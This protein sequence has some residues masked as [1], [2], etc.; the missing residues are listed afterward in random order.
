M[1]NYGLR[2]AV[3]LVIATMV[4]S[5]GA[6]S[7]EIAPDMA[8]PDG[9]AKAYILFLQRA[10]Y[11]RAYG[12]LTKSD[13]LQLSLDGYKETL[14][15]EAWKIKGT[16]VDSNLSQE[17]ESKVSAHLV[18]KTTDGPNQSIILNLV[19]APDGKWQVSHGDLAKAA[20]SAK[21]RIIADV[22]K[23]FGEGWKKHDYTSMSLALATDYLTRNFGASPYEAKLNDMRAKW[24]S[25]Y[26]PLEGIDCTADYVRY[27]KDT[28]ATIPAKF[29]YYDAANKTYRFAPYMVTLRFDLTSKQWKILELVRTSRYQRPPEAAAITSAETWKIEDEAI[30]GKPA[31]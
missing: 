17:S 12:L 31:K 14:G 13:Q 28:T 9:V 15:L 7:A 29:T 30:N 5:M 16:I 4:L 20:A 24:E 22:V 19:K 6:L 10:D 2:T 3:Y 8:S 11:A 18:L 1:L 27:I 21:S 25:D 26:G 23:R